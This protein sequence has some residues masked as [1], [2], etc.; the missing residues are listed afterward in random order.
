LSAQALAKRG[1]EVSESSSGDTHANT[2]VEVRYV[3]EATRFEATVPGSDE[4]AILEVKPSPDLW[5]FQHTEVPKSLEGQGIGSELV[6]QALRY[7]RELGVTIRPVCPFTAAYI[8][9]H[10]DELDLV[11][12]DFRDQIER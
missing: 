3:P 2:K 8:R 4:V 1:D 7:V 9:R 5:V 10:P 11:H 12:P 6:R